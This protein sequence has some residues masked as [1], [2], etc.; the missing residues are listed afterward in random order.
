[1]KKIALILLFVKMYSL[2]TAQQKHADVV[3]NEPEELHKAIVGSIAWG[4][5]GGPNYSSLKGSEIA[6]V[7][8]DDQA[9][10][11]PGFQIGFFTRARLSAKFSLEQELLYHQRRIGIQLSKESQRY[12]TTFSMAYIELKP[13]NI[14]FH[15]GKM[16]LF[17]GP[18]IG[19]LVQGSIRR[20]NEQDEFYRDRR[21]FG[22]GSND[23]TTNRYLQKFDFGA[24][25]GVAYQFSNQLG[26]SA[27]YLHGLTDIF[28][29][30]N[31]YTH[32]DSKTDKISIY[33]R[34][35]ALTVRYAFVR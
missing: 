19:A 24:N 12:N 25:L 15:I 1:M 10:Y 2:C 30:A 13:A 35:W 11:K 27:R 32:A 4:I 6:Y 28:Q 31:S 21:I 29:Y 5:L 34:G 3:S 20:K 18:Y 17:A 23:E 7:F 26:I 9:Y 14:G 22:Y 8:A 16:R 33:N